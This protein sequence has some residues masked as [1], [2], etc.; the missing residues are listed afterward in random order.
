MPAVYP[1]AVVSKNRY[2]YKFSHMRRENWCLK[3][4]ALSTVNYR[5]KLLAQNW[6]IQQ[7][8]GITSESKDQTGGK[9][10]NTDRGTEATGRYV[11][12][13]R[14]RIWFFVLAFAFRFDGYGSWKLK[15]NQQKKDL[16]C[17]HFSSARPIVVD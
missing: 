5:P 16:K 2:S 3:P 7:V 17:F 14:D 9:K 4:G 10:K 8:V 13:L 6:N 15:K 1:W 12:G 11:V